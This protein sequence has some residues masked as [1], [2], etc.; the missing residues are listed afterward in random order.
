M[1]QKR[2][3]CFLIYTTI[4]NLWLLNIYTQREL[5]FDIVYHEN[6]NGFVES[7]HCLT[8]SVCSALVCFR[9]SLAA[10]LSTLSSVEKMSGCGCTI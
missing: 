5:Q 8:D 3:C 2:S 10:L 7:N 4:I 6:V 1:K 9:R